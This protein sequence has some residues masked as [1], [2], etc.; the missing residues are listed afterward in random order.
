MFVF[1]P[2]QRSPWLRLAYMQDRLRIGWGSVRVGL[3][4]YFAASCLKFGFALAFSFF[5][6]SH[7]VFLFS[8]A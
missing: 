4:A 2:A 7:I 8:D 1:T 6:G 5:F 3:G